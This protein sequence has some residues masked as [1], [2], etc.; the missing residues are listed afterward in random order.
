[1]RA[2][3]TSG[4]IALVLFTGLAWYLSPLEPGVVALQ[5]AHTPAAFGEILSLWSAEDLLRY[6]RHLPVDFLLLAAYGAFGHLLVTRTRTWGSGSDSLRRLASWLL[7]LAAFFD[8]A[9]NVLHGWLIEGPRLG[10]PFLYSASA[11]CSLLKW[12][13]IVGFGL[14]MIHG[15]V[16]QRRQ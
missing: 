7:P 14:L 6:R 12:V 15:L 3:W 11:A 5:F 8:A 13:L 9:E 1:M 16:R 4:L 10:V 2:V